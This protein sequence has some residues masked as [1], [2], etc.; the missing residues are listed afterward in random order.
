MTKFLK[1][2]SPMSNSKHDVNT[3]GTDGRL[4]QIEYAMKASNLGTSSIGF[5]VGNAAVMISEK[6]QLNPLQSLKSVVKHYKIYDHICLGFCGISGDAKCIVRIARNFCVD[7]YN[8]FRENVPI[9]ALLKFL[10]SLSLNFGSDDSSK[11]IFSR[12]F[13]VSMLLISFD[14]EPKL[15]LLDPSGSYLRYKAKPLGSAAQSLEL[16]LKEEY[17]KF[18]DFE[19]SMRMGMEMLAEVAR[20]PLNGNNVEVSIATENGIEFLNCEAIE[21][22]MK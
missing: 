21:S 13:G 15:Y 18:V 20:D 17:H 9:E 19:T 1:M 6:K 14:V 12:P 4:Y 16:K 2:E 5:T 22:F 3:Y 11:K 7:H 8:M 10:C